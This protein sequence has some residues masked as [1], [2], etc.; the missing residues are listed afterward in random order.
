M[1]LMIDG[2]A[3]GATPGQ[4]VL[5]VARRAG[6]DIP[7]LCHHSALRPFGGCRVCLVAVEQGGRRALLPSCGLEV[8]EGMRVETAAPDVKKART[9]VLRLLL[10][11]CPQVE[12]IKELAGRYGVS[13]PGLPVG[14]DDCVLCGLCVRVCSELVG[15]NALAFARRGPDSAVETPYD[16]PSEACIGC[17]ACAEVCPTGR[18]RVVDQKGQREIVP[19]KTRHELTAC[20]ECGRGYVTE[21]QLLFLEQRMGQKAD[22][23]RG[24]PACKGRRRAEELQRVF[25]RLLPG[26]EEV[27][28][29]T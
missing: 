6:I 21:K 28:D 1:E 20:P 11:R 13:E 16:E 14:E 10:A 8:A 22:V 23:L 2:V 27:L 24:C 19:F 17:G 5:E 12:S 3:C 15:A 9:M 4:T 7:V 18:I 26:R 29:V 25:E